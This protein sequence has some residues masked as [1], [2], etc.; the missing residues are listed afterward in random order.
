MPLIKAQIDQ[1]G[2]EQ[3]DQSQLIKKTIDI[4]AKVSIWYSVIL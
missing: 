3:D 4:K 1:R 2:W